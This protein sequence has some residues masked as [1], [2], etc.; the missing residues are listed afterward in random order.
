[1][2]CQNW[3]TNATVHQV[4]A[5]PTNARTQ[6]EQSDKHH[7]GIPVVQPLRCDQPWKDLAEYATRRRRSV[8]GADLVRLG[9]VLG[10]V[11]QHDDHELAVSAIGPPIDRR[12]GETR[13]CVT[14]TA[15]MAG[16]LPGRWL[17]WGYQ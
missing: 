5:R 16:Y 6:Q 9:Q 4:R 14:L 13:G 10:P 11:G 12:N 3:I 17:N 7:D 8:E 15:D 2:W 1:M